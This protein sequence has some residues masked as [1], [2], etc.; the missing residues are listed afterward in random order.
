MMFHKYPFDDFLT[1]LEKLRNIKSYWFVKLKERDFWTCECSFVFIDSN[2][3]E[4]MKL[5]CFQWNEDGDIEE[6]YGPISAEIYE[7]K[8]NFTTFATPEPTYPD[9]YYFISTYSDDEHSL[10]Y[11]LRK[12][13]PGHRWE[14]GIKS[15]YG[16]FF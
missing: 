15:S 1:T 3:E 7:T 2:W 11:T 10:H 6:V 14:E 13:Q 16:P 9:S 4:L 12:V 8:H 5:V